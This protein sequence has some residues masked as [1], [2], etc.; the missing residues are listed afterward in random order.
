[1]VSLV[2]R[3]QFEGWHHWPDATGEYEYLSNVHRHMFHVTAWLSLEKQDNKNNHRQV[4]FIATKRQLLEWCNNKMM[5]ASH[6]NDVIQWSCE[7]WAEE[8]CNNFPFSSVE[9]SEDGENGALFSQ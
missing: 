6:D 1:M 5:S 8:I 4:E 9:V 3:L 7:R 2:I